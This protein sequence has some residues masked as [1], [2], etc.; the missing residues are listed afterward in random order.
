MIEAECIQIGDFLCGQVEF[1]FKVIGDDPGEIAGRVGEVCD[2]E[3]GLVGEGAGSRFPVSA[4]GMFLTGPVGGKG[5][6]FFIIAPYIARVDERDGIDRR[7]YPGVG[8]KNGRIVTD[9]VDDDIR[10][11]NKGV[12][13]LG[14]AEIREEPLT[15]V[16]WAEAASA[17]GHFAGIGQR[18]SAG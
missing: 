3:S 18:G 8:V 16:V 1:R 11:E 13:G 10:V 9:F 15:G 6:T 2:V 17:I 14:S 4:D 7:R 12:G 5:I